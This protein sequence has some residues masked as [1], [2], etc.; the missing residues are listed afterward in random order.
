GISRDQ[1]GYLQRLAPLLHGQAEDRGHR[2]PRRQVPPPLRPEVA[3]RRHF[4]RSAEAPIGTRNAARP[5]GVF[6]LR[7]GESGASPAG[8]RC[9]ILA[10][11]APPGGAVDRRCSPASRPASNA[12]ALHALVADKEFAVS[13][14]VSITD[15]ANHSTQLPVVTGSVGP[16]AI[17]IGKLHKE[18][19]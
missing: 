9:A 1:G 4:G 13:Q 2:R 5:R 6:V 3:S 7:G 16:A 8:S 17:D 18:T 10:P 15:T 14:T 12:M 11:R 19:G